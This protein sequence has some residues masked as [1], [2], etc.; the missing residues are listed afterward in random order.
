MLLRSSAATNTGRVR[1][2][3]APS[4]GDDRIGVGGSGSVKGWQLRNSVEALLTQ[5]DLIPPGEAR[6]CSTAHTVAIQIPPLRVARRTDD[7][8]TTPHTDDSLGRATFNTRRKLAVH[9]NEQFCIEH[10]SMFERLTGD[11]DD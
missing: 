3:V 8:I 6:E 10:H 2:A 11:D 5:Q 4:S 9:P 7:R 1:G